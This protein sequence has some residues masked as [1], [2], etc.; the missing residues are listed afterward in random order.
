MNG[1]EVDGP[2][3]V[4]ANEVGAQLCEVGVR[5]HS[6]SAECLRAI[7]ALQT[8]FQQ[9]VGIQALHIRGHVQNPCLVHKVDR[10]SRQ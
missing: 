2:D 5:V 3:L 8:H 10:S 1:C 7:E 9:M 6:C 4:V